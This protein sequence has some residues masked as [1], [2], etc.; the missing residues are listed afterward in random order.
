MDIFHAIVLGVVE[1]VTEFLPVSSTGHLILASQ[2]LH[3]PE[4]EFLK[5]F[6]IAIQLGA[7][8]SVV[9]L[10]WRKLLQFEVM[11]RVAVAF[12]PAAVIG[13]VLYKAVKALLGSETTVLWA[14]LLGGVFLIAFEYWHTEKDD[15][16]EE[17]E[18][19]P[20]KTALL[21][22]LFQSLAMVPGVSRS[23]ATIVGGLLLG[24]KRTTIAEFSFLLAVPT[25]AAATGLD[26]IKNFESFSSDQFG[27][28]A[29]GFVMAFVVALGAIKFLLRYVK[30]RT[31]APFGVYRILLA[32]GF[33]F[34]LV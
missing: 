8:L 15:A 7:I 11:K 9:A 23:G 1:G 12:L 16:H 6:E 21:I 17:I 29:A 32:L 25:M 22:G 5:T 10:Y 27:V 31:F 33:F 34:L 19:L 26:L 18:T 2:L 4:T 3:V 24:L 20:Y 28:L 13:L 30:T 14:L